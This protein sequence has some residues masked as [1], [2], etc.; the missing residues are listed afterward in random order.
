[1]IKNRLLSYF[2]CMEIIKELF[3][4]VYM[5]FCNTHIAYIFQRSMC[6]AEISNV[7]QPKVDNSNYPKDPSVLMGNYNC[8]K[9]VSN[10]S[11]IKLKVIISKCYSLF[12][13]ILI[14]SSIIKT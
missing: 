7:L 6:I 4:H 3:Y 10:T 1:M 5:S 14:T 12:F 11:N 8:S 2:C 13:T 9:L